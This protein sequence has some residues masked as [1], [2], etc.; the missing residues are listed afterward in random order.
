MAFPFCSIAHRPSILT[1]SRPNS[2]ASFARLPVL[3]GTATLKSYAFMTFLLYRV[4]EVTSW[5][6]PRVRVLQLKCKWCEARIVCDRRT[7]FE[8]SCRVERRD[9]SY[10]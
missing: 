8:T 10:V 6:P 2:S 5:Q 9:L 1:F 7:P 4:A 3:C